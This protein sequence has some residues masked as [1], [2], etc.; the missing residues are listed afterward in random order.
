MRRFYSSNDRRRFQRLKVNLSVFYKVIS[1][2]YVRAL[3]GDGE[4]EATTLDVG[5]GGMAFF[6]KHDIPPW[7]MLSLR[8][9]LFR[10]DDEGLV[11]FSDPVEIGAQTRSN[12]PIDNGEY[13]IGV[14][15]KAIAI[16]DMEEINGFVTS[17]L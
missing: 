14:C 3:T 8:F 7:S 10:A 17:A 6:T 12:I 5:A 4:I 2:E 11:S 1:P 9:Y 15:F 13:R 16:K